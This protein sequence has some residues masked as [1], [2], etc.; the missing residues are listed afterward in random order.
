MALRSV[1]RT[2]I[3]WLPCEGLSVAQ[4]HELHPPQSHRT[5]SWAVT[6]S[7]CRRL[8]NKPNIVFLGP[9]LSA[10]ITAR[11]AEAIY[12]LNIRFTQLSHLLS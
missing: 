3:P 1:S 6:T 7:L 8:G 2:Q 4:M 10:L 5:Y 9:N 11:M 12:F